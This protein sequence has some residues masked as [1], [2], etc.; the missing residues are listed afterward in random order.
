MQMTRYI[1]VQ[2]AFEGVHCWPNAPEQVAFLRNPHRH[3][4][5][6]SAIMETFHNDREV[7]FIMVK[8]AIEDF[9]QDV[10]WPIAVSCE[11]MAE[12]IGNFLQ[13]RYG[14]HRFVSVSVSED[15]E[16]GA[17]VQ[18]DSKPLTFAD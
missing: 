5:H 17:I 11:M 9:L 8:H 16:N 10:E 4:F 18:P 13:Q 3:M 14:D 1:K 6:V 2:T 7:E 15:N 12:D